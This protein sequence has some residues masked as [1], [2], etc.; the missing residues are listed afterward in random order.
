MF[1]VVQGV[2][3]RPFIYR[4]A[5]KHRLHGF[6]LNNSQGVTIHWE[7]EARSIDQAL[8]AMLN[9]PPPLAKIT[10]YSCREIEPNKYSSFF[11]QES[12]VRE[13][14]EA[15]IP[16]DVGI[17]SDCMR[18]LQD[19][20]DRRF[21]YPFTNCTNCGPRF[22]I[23]R[24]MPYDRRQTTMNQFDMCPS[25]QAE[26]DDPENRRFH[27]Q[28]NACGRCGPR[29]ELWD[30]MG[31]IVNEDPHRL[32]LA[33]N[34]LAV[35]GLGG[36]HLACNAM[37]EEAVDRLRQLK[38]RD[39]KPFALMAADLETVRRCCRLSAAE[40]EQLISPVRP[41]VVLQQQDLSLP[42]AINPALDSLGIMLPYTPLHQL[43]LSPTLSLVVMTSANL[44]SNPLITANKEAL[45]QLGEIA[46]F[47]LV[48]NRGIVNPCDDSVGA[49]TGGSWQY[50]RR[51]RGCVPLPVHLRGK[52][53]TPLLACG[54]NFKNTFALTK[55]E[56]VFLSQHWGDLDNY[57]NYLKYEEAV[58]KMMSLLD[59]K[60]ELV[61]HD[62]HPDYQTTAFAGKL[63]RD[64]S[65]PAHAVQ[66][67]H[68]HMAS[69]M[70]DNG[71]D[72]EV[73]AVICDG[74]G[75]GTD[76]AI[77]GFEFLYGDYGSYS[78]LGHL[79]YLPLPG[80][81]ASIKKVDRMAYAFLISTLNNG[82]KQQAEQVLPR[83]GTKER[84]LLDIQVKRKINSPLTSSCGRL[85][86]AAAALLGICSI[87][88]YE[89]QAPMEM[90][91]KARHSTDKGQ[92]YRL[93]LAKNGDGT[94]TLNTAALWAEMLEDILAGKEP[95]TLAL[96]FHWAVARAI[97]DGVLHMAAV[98]GLDKVVFSG[99]VFQNRLLTAMVKELMAETKIDEYL[100]RQVP[101]N[102][103]GVS[104]G[105]ALI[106]NEVQK[107][108][109]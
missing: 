8:A 18:E 60:P 28:P 39:A 44:S 2:G 47:F 65:L 20:A 61:V 85:F 43:L 31:N 58:P 94:F 33:G 29:M 9:S 15:L 75:Y 68:A 5:G 27:A 80:G 90:E 107:R 82:V 59:I 86:D 103:G 96:K 52:E 74:T 53:M 38:K 30:H 3:F 57:L 66:H 40:E 92:Y 83:L 56:K 62:L 108:C 72:E 102:D 51:A 98:T 34:I 42:Q 79:H 49:V 71:L 99:G 12:L 13:G 55:G 87:N 77:W 95:G 35:K 88:K 1:G 73:M 76:G 84:E 63:C 32:L 91:A 14:I 93:E 6:V 54:P 101:P 104:L 48:H 67:H 46:D 4:L 78:R 109:V 37:D 69:C 19:A 23:I 7:G 106:G 22:T 100:H 24:D 70:A 81:E 36:F 16:P 25:C 21:S 10:S 105:Q 17:C 50:T 97:I 11:I 45:E 89:G 41:I 26:Y 64:L